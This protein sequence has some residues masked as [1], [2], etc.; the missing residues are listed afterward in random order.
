MKK[1]HWTAV[2]EFIVIKPTNEMEKKGEVLKLSMF[3]E[4]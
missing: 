2:T 4:F 3:G 1:S